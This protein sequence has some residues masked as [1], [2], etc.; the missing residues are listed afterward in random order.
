[1]KEIRD[2]MNKYKTILED[3]K[4]DKHT[5]NY[6]YEKKN[7]N[8][9]Y[10]DEETRFILEKNLFIIEKFNGYEFHLFFNKPKMVIYS[11]IGKTQSLIFSTLQ[12]DE[13]MKK[14]FI[15]ELEFQ[16]DN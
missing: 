6:I 12:I 1:M 15:Q 8:E 7:K 13:F 11:N 10:L 14:N 5:Y 3:L 9:T 2:E 4:F 16:I